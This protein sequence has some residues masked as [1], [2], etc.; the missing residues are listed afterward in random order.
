M[1]IGILGTGAVGRTL[2]EGFVRTGHDVFVGTRD[3]HVTTVRPLSEGGPAFADWL[4]DN[5]RIALVDMASAAE[6]AEVVVNATSGA[7]SIG[8][9]TS[10]GSANLAGKPLVDVANPLD[11]SGGFPPTLTIKDTDSLGEAIQRAF[12]E[13]HVVKALNTL[14]AALM[15]RPDLLPEPTTL[16]IAGND[17][18]AK[19][20]VTRLLGEFGWA[21]VLDLG[22]ISSARGTEMW[23][24][25][26]LRTMQALG[27]PMFNLRVVRAEQG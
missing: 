12:P 10:A 8:A 16:P 9:L 20:T 1:R 15:T 22:E 3:V 6:S 4:A 27:S 19:A 26:W 11:F 18:A 17:P 7:A 5:P 14:T 23:L 21:D 2:A 25:L 24:A 13:A